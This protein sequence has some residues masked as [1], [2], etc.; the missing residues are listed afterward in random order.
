MLLSELEENASVRAW[1]ERFVWE[2]TQADNI[3]D[4]DP[5]HFNVW[6]TLNAGEKGYAFHYLLGVFA[7]TVGAAKEDDE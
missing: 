2:I 3:N 1:I 5:N 6:D 7:D 4:I